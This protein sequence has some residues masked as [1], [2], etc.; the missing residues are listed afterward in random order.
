MAPLT[1]I[2]I[3]QNCT[4]RSELW[5]KYGGSTEWHYRPIKV[6]KIADIVWQHPCC[7]S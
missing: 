2:C 1:K 5:L 3:S 7:Q 6:Q 4:I